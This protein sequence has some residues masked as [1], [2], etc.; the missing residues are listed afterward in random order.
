[1]YFVNSDHYKYK[2]YL[3][4]IVDVL[5]LSNLSNIELKIGLSQL[6][7]FCYIN[8][9]ESILKNYFLSRNL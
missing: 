8:R 2:E 6:D 5:F 7:L 1:M 9:T 4:T 3:A